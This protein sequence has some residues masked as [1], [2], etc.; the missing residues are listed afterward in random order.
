MVLPSGDQDGARSA[1]P[2]VWVEV[3]GVTLFGGDGEDVSMGLNGHALGGGGE[4]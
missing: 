3:A 1:I 4:A 2:G